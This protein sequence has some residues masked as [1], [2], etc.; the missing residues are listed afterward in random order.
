MQ[1]KWLISI[2]IYAIWILIQ[3]Q[4]VHHSCMTELQT[5]SSS[6]YKA[7]V[8][9]FQSYECVFICINIFIHDKLV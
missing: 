5:V 3:Q 9:L 8:F 7:T 6:H 2:Q 4:Y 1:Y